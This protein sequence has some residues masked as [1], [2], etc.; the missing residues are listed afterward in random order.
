MASI[1][2]TL[3]HRSQVL[4]GT[5]LWASSIVR[6]LNL[7]SLTMH[8]LLSMLASFL[9][10]VSESKSSHIC[11]ACLQQTPMMK[12]LPEPSRCVTRVQTGCCTPAQQ[13]SLIRH[14]AACHWCLPSKFQLCA[15]RAQLTSLRRLLA[16]GRSI[17]KSRLRKPQALLMKRSGCA[18]RQGMNQPGS[19]GL[20]NESPPAVLALQREP[21]MLTRLLV[22]ITCTLGE[23][24]P[25]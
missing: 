20:S 16:E 23:H 4:A 9:D 1:T 21:R 15:P 8:T 7:C 19:A 12:E 17:G 10:H 11:A 6:F 5:G 3:L 13:H 14:C 22:R 2:H 24:A 18:L 25:S